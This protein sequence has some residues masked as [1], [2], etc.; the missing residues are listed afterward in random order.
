MVVLSVAKCCPEGLDLC[1]SC[2]EPCKGA[3]FLTARDEGAPAARAKKG[4]F[5]G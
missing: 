2:S 5:G 1:L 3:S 4:W